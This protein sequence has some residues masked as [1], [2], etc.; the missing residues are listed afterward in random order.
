MHTQSEQVR[1][2]EDMDRYSLT[3]CPWNGTLVPIGQ[4]DYWGWVVK[5]TGLEV[6]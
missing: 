3:V 4:S 1:L 6:P 2:Y 5:I